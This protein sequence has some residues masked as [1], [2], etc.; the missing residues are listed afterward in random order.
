MATQSGDTTIVDMELCEVKT[1]AE[2]EDEDPNEV[3]MTKQEAIVFAKSHPPIIDMMQAI[4]GLKVLGLPEDSDLYER[5]P[6]D[7]AM[8]AL[9]LYH[10][11]TKLSSEA[12]TSKQQTR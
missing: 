7:R 4:A 11:P 9:A 5:R 10:H 6:I 12:G 3:M 8:R 2:E 1:E